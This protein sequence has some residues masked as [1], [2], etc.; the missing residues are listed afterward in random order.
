[1][2]LHPPLFIA[3]LDCS[4]MKSKLIGRNSPELTNQNVF[5]STSLIASLSNIHQNVKHEESVDMSQCIW[6]RIKDYFM[7][8]TGTDSYCDQI[9]AIYW[10]IQTALSHSTMIIIGNPVLTYSHIIILHILLNINDYLI[11]PIVFTKVQC[12]CHKN[13]YVNRCTLKHSHSAWLQIPFI[14]TYPSDLEKSSLKFTGMEN[15]TPESYAIMSFWCCGTIQ[16]MFDSD[17]HFL[18]PTEYP[19][20]LWFDLGL[21]SM[22]KKFLYNL[23]QLA[24]R[25]FTIQTFLVGH[26]SECHWEY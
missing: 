3:V 22:V 6:I 11:F 24:S 5:I 18:Q 25:F 17:C 14:H 15:Y 26:K 13:Q 19:M 20:W 23:S 7:T 2:H 16:R 21:S 8:H 9:N 10:H 1:M 4:P 12:M